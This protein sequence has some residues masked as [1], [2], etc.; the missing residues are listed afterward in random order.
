MSFL[1]SLLGRTRLPKANEDRLFAMST[2]AVALEVAGLKPSGRAGIV[3]KRLPPGRFDQLMADVRQ[4]L[5]MQGQD[6]DLKAEEHPDALGFDW[7]ILTGGSPDYQDALAAIHTVAQSLIEEGLG[8]LLLASVFRF[9]QNERPVYWIYGYK[10]AAFYPFV[11]T[12]D[13]QRDNSEELRLAAVAKAELPVEP[14][15]ER[16]YALWGI[17][18]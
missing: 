4:L 18:V 2:A 7:M 10:E 13:R 11:P 9:Q 14:L 5:Q 15:L 1:D 8:D 12:G 17:P 3:F 16:W 6:S